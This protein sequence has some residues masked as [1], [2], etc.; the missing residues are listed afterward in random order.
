VLL[1]GTEQVAL[2]PRSLIWLF[3]WQEH[4]L[5]GHSEGFELWTACFRPWLIR[6]CAN[7]GGEQVLRER[8]KI[9]I[10]C[11]RLGVPAGPTPRDTARRGE[12][13]GEPSTY[14]AGLA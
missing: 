13:F 1:V 6:R 5:V 10:H 12:A 3:L 7:S 14:Y 4:L 9:G 11:R 2:E 8:C